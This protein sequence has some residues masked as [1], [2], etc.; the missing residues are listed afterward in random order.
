MPPSR[1]RFARA[2]RERWRKVGDAF[3]T[4]FARTGNTAENTFHT[5][6]GSPSGLPEKVAGEPAET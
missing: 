3:V 4:V 1:N 6:V 5:T 2:W